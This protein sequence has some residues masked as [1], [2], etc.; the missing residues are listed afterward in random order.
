[1]KALRS[2][3]VDILVSL[4]TRDE[5]T[6]LGLSDE[7]HHCEASG[8]VFLSFPITDRGTPG[9]DG[10]ALALIRQLS[11]SVSDAKAIAIHCRM[12]IGRSSLIAASVLVMLGIDGEHAFDL[13]ATARGL[14]VPDT[15]AQR[16]WV[17]DVCSQRSL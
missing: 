8:M 2:A 15:K 1:M 7:R 13:L 10:E 12:G 5:E 16:Q 4:L 9:S 11:R 14:A 3:G 6:E 17:L